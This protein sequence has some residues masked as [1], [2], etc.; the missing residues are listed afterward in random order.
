MTIDVV[1]PF[2]GSFSYLRQAV[3]SVIAQTDPDWH[4]TVIDDVYPDLEPGNWVKSLA[5]S[6]VTYVRNTSNLGV[7]GNFNESVEHM[8]GAWAVV[9]GGDDIMLPGFVARAKR[10]VELAPEA[11]VIQMGVEIIDEDNATYLPLVDRMKR[12]YRFRGTGL[13]QY[14][15]EHLASSLL[16]G[17]WTYFPALL[18]RVDVLRHYEFRADLVTAPD[19]VMLLD[20]TADG[21]TLALDD[22]VEF[23]YRRHRR[24]VSSLAAI[25]GSRFAEERAMFDEQA[26]RFSALG[27]LRAARA[28]RRHYS[29]RL[30]AIT[31][32]PAAVVQADG[33]AVRRLVA[34]AVGV[35]PR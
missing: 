9:L 3:E 35:R 18:W 13:R 17:N 28:A 12:Y 10:L 19:L 14:S 6:R 7:A 16:R 34:H 27:W 30:N 15:G 32:I 26:E 11:S 23:R 31:R 2:Y 21:G 1:L 8:S 4:L 33:I 20:I 29:S 22:Q 25:D 24:S 5:D